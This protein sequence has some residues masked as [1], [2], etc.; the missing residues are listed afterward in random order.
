MKLSIIT[1]TILRESLY[2]TCKSIDIQR[3]C[4]YEHI[5]IVDIPQEELTKSQVNMIKILQ[6]QDT[7]NKR[8]F[9]YCNKRHHNVGNTCKHDAFKYVT[10]F[11]VMSMD[12]D[13]CYLHTN[14]FQLI[15][16]GLL[17]A[18]KPD[19]AVFPILR[20]GVRF[21]N[22][23]PQLGMTCSNQYIYKRY[24]KGRA[25][26]FPDSDIYEQDGLWLNDIHRWYPNYGVLNIPEVASV[27]LVS[28]G[29]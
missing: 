21:F 27:D 15:V 16:S 5:V 3:N 24:I 2:K 4:D 12:D 8:T 1:P 29:A 11:Y 22:L 23:P 14:D 25:M 26:Q 6:K 28:R 20:M 18:R 17:Q 9:Y 19:W 10:G 7:K 13:D